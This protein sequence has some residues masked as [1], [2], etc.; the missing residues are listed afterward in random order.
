[1]TE[2]TPEPELTIAEQREAEAK[3]RNLQAVRALRE[4]L[5]GKK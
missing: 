1:M 5:G 4:K 2:P 3:E